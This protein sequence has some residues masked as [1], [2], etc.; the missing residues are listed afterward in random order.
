MEN[1]NIDNIKKDIAEQ[2]HFINMSKKKSEAYLALCITSFLT[3]ICSVFF[4][5][6]LICIGFFTISFLCL[7]GYNKSIGQLEVHMSIKKF[8]KMVLIQEQTGEDVFKSIVS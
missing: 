7:R 2:E 4:S 3:F 6:L 1:V 8:L 5:H